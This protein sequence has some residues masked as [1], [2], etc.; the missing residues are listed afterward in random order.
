MIAEKIVVMGAG[1]VGCYYGALLALNGHQVT[2][3][4]RPG[5]VEAVATKGLLLERQSGIETVAL[6]ASESVEAVAD[7]S[8]VLLT[9]KS[10]DTETAGR[11]IAPHL[12]SNSI[13]LSMQ[14]GIGNAERLAVILGRPVTPVVVYIAAEMA[15]PGHMRHRGRGELVFPEGPNSPKLA[16]LFNDAGAPATVSNTAETAMWTKFVV[17][18]CV[19][20]L[21]A[22]TNETYDRI[23]MHEGAEQLVKDTMHECVAVA[24]ASGVSLPD[25]IWEIIWNVFP[26]MVGQRSSTAQDLIRGRKTEI[27]HFNGEIV[28]KAR[29]FGIDVPVN[30][31]LWAMVKIAESR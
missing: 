19:N 26:T 27:D 9:V 11:A 7:A 28:R 29:K 16:S 21:S 18:C 20:A 5:L 1:A 4:G 10:G 6:A 30:N 24:S 13:V 23:A 2:L 25:N 31:A 8:I 15:G 17:N 12:A 14:N 22:L 3:I